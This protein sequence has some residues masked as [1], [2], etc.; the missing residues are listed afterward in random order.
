MGIFFYILGLAIGGFLGYHAGRATR[1]PNPEQEKQF[2]GCRLAVI[3]LVKENHKLRQE[4]RRRFT[5][6]NN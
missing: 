3:N 4:R 5:V 1:D 6:E 2:E